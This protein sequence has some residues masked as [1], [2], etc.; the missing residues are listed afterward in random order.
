MKTYC[1]LVG[2]LLSSL[3]LQ[4]QQTLFSVPSSDMTPAHQILAQVQLDINRQEVRSMTTVTYGLGHNWEAG[5]NLYHLDYQRPEHTWLRNDTTIQIPYAP[6]LLL[7][8]QKTVDFNENL[9]LGLGGQT[10]VN[11]AVRHQS[12]WVGWGYAN[13]GWDFSH[14]HYKAVAGLYAGN[15][16]YLADG[17]RAGFHLGLDAGIWY[18]KLHLMADWAT[19]KHDYGQLV[20]GA[21]VYLGSHL[22]LA[23]GWRRSNQDGGQALVVQLT[24]SP[25]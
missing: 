11:V 2:L 10:G 16:R 21:E 20:L 4:A 13:L 22:P 6:L 15:H 8:A 7:N 1:F 14:H 19:G 18:E 9:H 23:V 25:H 3:T 24:Y 17:P 12:A 5:L